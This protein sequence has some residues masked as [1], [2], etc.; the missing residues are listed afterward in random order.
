MMDGE[1]KDEIQ[2]RMSQQ[3]FQSAIQTGVQDA[4]LGILVFLFGL[5]MAAAFV[6]AGAQMIIQTPGIGW[7][8]I[9][10]LNMLLGVGIFVWAWKLV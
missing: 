3:E 7:D 9:G 10:G 6:F 4:L 1:K 8:L 5:L 2:L